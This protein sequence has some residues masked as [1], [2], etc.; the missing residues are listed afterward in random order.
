MR[1]ALKHHCTG[2]PG[3]DAVDRSDAGDEAGT[4]DEPPQRSGAKERGSN[5]G[6]EQ[7]PIMAERDD[8]RGRDAS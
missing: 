2:G 1:L 4:A 5:D 7:Q 3:R 8:D 6:A